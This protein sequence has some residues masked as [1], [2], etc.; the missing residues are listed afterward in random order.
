MSTNTMLKSTC[1]FDA[2]TNFG[3]QNVT[4]VGSKQSTKKS[5]KPLGVMEKARHNMYREILC[6][7]EV[8]ELL[9]ISHSS[10]YKL[11][12]RRLIK[13][14]RVGRRRLISRAA[15]DNF[16]EEQERNSYE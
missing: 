1:A 3:P 7:K 5:I 11:L 15:I 8:E 6:V 12:D 14:F 4:N 16:I 9:G 2:N 10:L 13:S